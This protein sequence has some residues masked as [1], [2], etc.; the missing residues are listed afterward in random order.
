[1]T[2]DN[3][4]HAQYSFDGSQIDD[5]QL[6][7]RPVI[8]APINWGWSLEDRFTDTSQQNAAGLNIPTTIK[9]GAPK[10]SV[11]GIVSVNAAGEFTLLKKGPLM[12]KTRANVGRTGTNGIS[13]MFVWMETS[14][15]GG[16]TWQSY[17]NSGF[18]QLDTT[19]DQ[20]TF[21][22]FAMFDLPVGIFVRARFARDG[23][24][25]NDGSLVVDSPSSALAT[26]G[27]PDSA[28]AQL[29][30]YKVTEFIYV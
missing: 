3:L 16:S 23:S 17:G 30:A 14:I 5:P 1:M 25:V 15:N 20:K 11:N 28:S 24:G 19:S 21:L 2:L 8:P 29:T 12:V 27:C 22:D 18:V 7:I 13:N 6:L 10:S 4:R 9:F 26:A